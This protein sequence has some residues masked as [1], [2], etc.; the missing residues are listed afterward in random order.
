MKDVRKY[1]VYPSDLDI[2]LSFRKL[3]EYFSRN[4]YKEDNR[5]CDRVNYIL[6]MNEERSLKPNS[7]SEFL[8]AIQD[9]PN[10]I[11]IWMHSH[12]QDNKRVRFEI[13]I[14]LRLSKLEIA[15]GSDD[16]NAISAIHDKVKEIFEASN[17]QLER[18]P[19]M[20]RYN[21]K[22]SIFLAHKFDEIGRTT[23]L[24][25]S[26]FLRRLGFEVLEGEG[27]EN[28]NIPEKV[29]ER[30]RRQ[31]IFLCIVTPGDASWI[32][33]EISFAKGLDKYI[34]IVTQDALPFNKG[35]I[36]SDFEHMSFPE[37]NIEKIFS[38]LLYTLPL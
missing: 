13:E 36:G 38:A 29:V 1:R 21:L 11:P 31:D 19:Q 23:A 4:N 3:G 30:I 32:L 6:N 16:L 14:D 34:I 2:V 22:K 15:I 7:F 28:R 8:T 9:Y 12:W 20:S 33:S 25:L 5:G 18:S 10:S 27:Y 35:I 24:T 37:G 17:P 26:T